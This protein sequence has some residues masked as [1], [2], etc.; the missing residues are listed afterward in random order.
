MNWLK[1][2]AVRLLVC[3]IL[4]VGLVVATNI[5]GIDMLTVRFWAGYAVL[6]VFDILQR[7]ARELVEKRGG[8]S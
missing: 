4:A 3:C 7:A 6:T 8:A 5:W 1:A 2:V